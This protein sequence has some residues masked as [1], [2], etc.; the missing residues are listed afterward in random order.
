MPGNRGND[1]QRTEPNGTGPS[2][3]EIPADDVAPAHEGG[4]D[5][6]DKVALIV[7]GTAADGQTLA[8]A[9]A[10]RGMHVILLYFHEKHQ[11]ASALKEKVEAQERR[12]LLISRVGFAADNEG[13]HFVEHA[14]QQ[15]R[16]TFGRLDVF[17]NLSTS[18]R[19]LNGNG[20]GQVQGPKLGSRL[21]PNLDIMKAALNRIVESEHGG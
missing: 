13:K 16:E 14:M 1:R 7:D 6:Q 12:C 20:A 2:G 8:L 5:L 21:F 9:L 18:P 4:V 3:R 19:I 11:L 17:V 10:R 15:I